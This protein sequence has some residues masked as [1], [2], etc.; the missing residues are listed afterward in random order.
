MPK[1][2]QAVL[3]GVASFFPWLF[4]G[5]T[6]GLVPAFIFVAVYYF[7]AQ[8]FLSRGRA[9]AYAT[10]WTTM[11]ALDASTFVVAII[12]TAVENRGVLVTQT[13]PLLISVVGGTFAGAV[14][15]ALAA[16]RPELPPS[17]E[18]RKGLIVA[19]GA[20]VFGSAALAIS[21]ILGHLL[22]QA[23]P[24]HGW[25]L[26]GAITFAGGA[27]GSAWGAHVADHM[28]GRLALVMSASLAIG[29]LSWAVWVLARTFQPT[30][31]F[32]LLTFLA[33]AAALLATAV[34]VER[35]TAVRWRA[36]LPPSSPSPHAAR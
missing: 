20:C 24:V 35:L 34:W 11:L 4:L 5:E 12:S 6:V 25:W 1:P 29:T 9:R 22:A 33:S 16:R 32:P 8:L 28:E 36:S 18:L 13:I 26:G 23:A 31:P 30:G 3:L 15:A 27:L 7:V 21:G 10:D 19:G 2:G 14:A 17:T